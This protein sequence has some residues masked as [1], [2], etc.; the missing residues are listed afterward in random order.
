MRLARRQRVQSQA[1]QHP[2]VAPASEVVKKCQ[3]SDASCDCGDK[4]KFEHC[5]VLSLGVVLSLPSTRE[6][7][8]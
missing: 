1:V 3:E 8:V 6:Y 7:H 4:F 2:S 5:V